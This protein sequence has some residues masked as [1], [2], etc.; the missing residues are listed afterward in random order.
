M[1]TLIECGILDAAGNRSY[2]VNIE[3]FDDNLEV[4]RAVCDPEKRLLVR[5]TVLVKKLKFSASRVAMILKRLAQRNVDGIFQASGY[6]HKS[7]HSA[8]LRK[9]AYFVTVEISN[10]IQDAIA[11][12]STSSKHGRCR[13]DLI[14]TKSSV[15]TV[16]PAPSN[17]IRADVRKED[18]FPVKNQVYLAESTDY[19]VPTNLSRRSSFPVEL[20]NHPL[21]PVMAPGSHPRGYLSP[22]YSGAVSF[23]IVHPQAWSRHPT[24]MQFSW[25][26]V[27]GPNQHRH[28]S[29]PSS[30]DFSPRSSIFKSPKDV[31]HML[32]PNQLRLRNPYS[33]A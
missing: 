2:F 9:N 22:P 1:R 14:S 10:L 3:G 32:D 33:M 25:P 30:L 15:S 28:H 5:P 18:V 7:S 13:L 26:V 16:K 27:H 17:I 4:F 6:L 19:Q 8:L 21:S 29:H 24:H 31:H 23:P 11:G 20:P 12:P